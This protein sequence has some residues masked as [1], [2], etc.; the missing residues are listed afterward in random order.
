MLFNGR[1]PIIMVS[2][3]LV[4]ITEIE[5]RQSLCFCYTLYC[6]YNRPCALRNNSSKEHRELVGGNEL[7]T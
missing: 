5:R 7:Q 6:A 4:R 2:R 3:T 1:A